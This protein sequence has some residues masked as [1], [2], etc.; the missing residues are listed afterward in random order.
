MTRVRRVIRI[1]AFLLAV[2]VVYAALFAPIATAV[3]T[4]SQ[5]YYAK[6]SIALGS[7]VSLKQD[8][9]DEITLANIENSQNIFGVAISADSSLLSIQGKEGSQVQVATGGTIDVLVTNANGNIKK[10]D[11]I[12][13][14]QFA[15]VGMKATE[16]TRIVGSA[17]ADA[18]AG[19]KQT[20][21]L[22]NGKQESVNVTQIPVLVNI[23]YFFKE[24]E[25]TIIPTALQDVANSIAGKKVDALPIIVSIVIFILMIIVVVSIVYSMIRNSIIATGRNP[26]SQASIYRN[27]L[28]LSAL[29]IA[30]LSVGIVS[31]YLILTKL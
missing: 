30:I 3:T 25:K 22:K 28:Q 23:T 6:D 16:N 2:S 5:G 29:V 1:R 18:K 14:S 4:I 17:Q 12:T 15:G 7:I 21:K 26:L 11:P 13:A 9:E 10:G 24:P 20:Y 19:T 8:T 31:I 27:L